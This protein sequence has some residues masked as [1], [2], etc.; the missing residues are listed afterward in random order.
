[1]WWAE[2]L[3]GYVAE[4]ERHVTHSPLRCRRTLA[5]AGVLAFLMA[6]GGPVLARS[7][8]NSGRGASKPV[9]KVITKAS[10]Y[11]A[12]FK[13]RP[14]ASG[15]LFNPNDL[16]GAHRTLPLGSH[17]RVTD[18]RA[19]RSVVVKIVDRGPFVDGRGIDLSYAA[20]QRLG[21]VK[22]G[23]ARV[24]L[25]VI[26]DPTKPPLRIAQASRPGGQFPGALLR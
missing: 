15:V 21:M 10:W 11:G 24:S 8:G 14:T 3:S 13:N 9:K 16:I 17:V 18:V 5:S 1:M 19:G 26:P 2:P 6:A 25:E 12:R 7:P 22:R 4:G 20:A 23:V